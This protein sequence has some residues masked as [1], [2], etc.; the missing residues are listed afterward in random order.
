MNKSVDD[1][2]EAIY[3]IMPRGILDY[4]MMIYIN[5]PDELNN[6]QNPL[7]NYYIT[8]TSK[9]IFQNYK[10]SK[11]LGIKTID[12]P[13]RLA[14]VINRYVKMNNIRVGDKLLKLSSCALYCHI[15]KIFNCNT[16]ELR[17]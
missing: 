5:S 14:K 16:Y 8:N 6:F 4:S 12:V 17:R 2:I 11:K 13:Q 7:N 10:N 3:S 9:F 15:K 1:V